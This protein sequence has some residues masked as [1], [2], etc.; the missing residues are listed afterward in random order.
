MAADTQPLAGNVALVTGASRGIGRATALELARA[1]AIVGL[2]ARST[3]ASPS[4]LAGTI[5]SV[6]AE[7]AALGGRVL[8]A[9]ADI[10]SEEQVQEGWS[11]VERELGPVDI[12]VNNAAYM[13]SAP[14]LETPL[15]RWDLTMSVNLRGA[16]VCTQAFA[17]RAIQR[18][19]GR[20]INVSSS[21]TAILEPQYVSYAVSKAAL[22]TLTQFLAAELSGRGIAVNALRIDR[23]VSTEGARLLNPDQDVSEWEKPEQTARTVRWLAEQPVEFTGNV[24]T[25]ADARERFAAP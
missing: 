5:E 24:L 7:V 4:R 23:S 12:L 21:A 6:A 2:I 14:F 22:E 9:A 8:T 19:H 15:K 10:T 18:G 20:V 11:R 16:I 3:R 25:L 1:G 17:G 13:Y